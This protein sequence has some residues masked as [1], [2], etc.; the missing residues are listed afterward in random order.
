MKVHVND[1]D[2]LCTVHDECVNNKEFP[3]Y[4]H[5]LLLKMKLVV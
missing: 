3:T 2:I 4:T 5:N 1:F